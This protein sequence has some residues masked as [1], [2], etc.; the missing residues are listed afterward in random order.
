MIPTYNLIFYFHTMTLHTDTGTTTVNVMGLLLIIILIALIAFIIILRALWSRGREQCT[1]REEVSITFVWNLID[2][3]NGQ[4]Q[5]GDQF[6]VLVLSS[7]RDNIEIMRF[8]PCDHSN[9]PLVDSHHALYPLQD[10]YENY[11]AARPDR[12]PSKFGYRS[13]HAEEMILTEFDSL[14]STYRRVEGCDPT[15]IVLYSWMMPCSDCTSAIIVWSNK[16]LNSQIVVVYT[17]DWTEISEQ[18][19]DDNRVRLHA[20]GIKVQRVKYNRRLPPA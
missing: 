13:V 12:V 15:Y 8:R 16:H 4:R 14:F 3:F 11:I 19:N 2:K 1:R 6:A 17:I 7:G 10:Q 5:V 20:A 18:E 9:N